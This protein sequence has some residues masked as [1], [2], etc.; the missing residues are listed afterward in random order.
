M[1]KF[2]VFLGT[3]V[4]ALTIPG[5][6]SAQ[7]TSGCYS[8]F[9]KNDYPNVFRECQDPAK[10]E[11]TYSQVNLGFL[12][13]YGE[14]VDQSY[15]EALKWY[16]K[17]AEGGHPEA[18]MLIDSIISDRRDVADSE[19]EELKITRKLAYLGNA[20]SQFNLALMYDN[21]Q[22]AAQSY[23]QSAKWYR[24]AA[25]QGNAKA[26]LNLCMMYDNGRG[27]AQSYSEAAKWYRKAADQG[28]ASAQFNLGVM[29]A[30]AQGLPENYVEAHRWTSLAAASGHQ[31]ARKNLKIIKGWMT[32]GQIAE[33]QQLATG[34]KV[35]AQASSWSAISRSNV[36]RLQRA[37]NDLGFSV[38][39]AD[40]I[41]GKRTKS[42]LATFQRIKG[43]PVGAP[44]A[45]TLIELGIK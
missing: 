36:K 15:S 25:D 14:G 43:L 33:A 24:K 19:T 21:G 18:Q 10:Q 2:I 32:P 6:A 28:N 8:A 5:F 22:G 41:P 38:G 3:A 9:M 13:Q 23:L 45:A 1:N 12:Y 39:P 42:A 44:D 11:D 17:A 26:Q 31:Q 16:R 27:V 30:K 29:Y 4:V 34:G 7:D 40:G 35:G 37:L 20:S